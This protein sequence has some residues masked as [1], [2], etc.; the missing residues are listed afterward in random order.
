MR[1]IG[2]SLGGILG[3][4]LARR[5]PGGVGRLVTLGSPMSLTVRRQSRARG[6]YER[7]G[8]LHVPEYAFDMLTKSLQV[9][10][11]TTSIYSHSD[12]IV[13]WEACRLPWGPLTENIEVYASHC[14]TGVHPAAVY[15]VL[16]RLAAPLDP[17]ER[18]APPAHLRRYFPNPA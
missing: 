5:N 7:Y 9:T 11:P 13:R 10:V 2:Q 14:G 15:A 3:R 12:G 6:L 4:E 17:W 8:R 1:V 16:D 18:F